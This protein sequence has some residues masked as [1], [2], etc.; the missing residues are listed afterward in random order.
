VGLTEHAIVYAGTSMESPRLLDIQ[1]G[2]VA[3]F[4]RQG[5]HKETVNEDAVAVIPAPGDA[6][7][8]VVADGLGGLPAGDMASAIAVESLVNSIQGAGEYSLRESILDGIEHANRKILD[9]GTGAATTLAVV[10][11]RN[12]ILRSYHIGD[13]GVIVTGQRGRRRLQTVS[14]SPTGYAQEA[15][16]INEAEALDHEERNLVSNVVG[17]HDLRIEIG[18]LLRIA[19]RDTVIVASDG[20]LDNFLSEEIIEY[21]RRGKMQLAATALAVECL[22]RME[23][24]DSNDVGGHPDDI[25]FILYRRT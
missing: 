13:A 9:H 21:I 17:S 19:P 4:T 22:S 1:A 24:G 8:L 16:L 11:I 7:V 20:L 18:S 12:N 3:V 23:R 6:V 5:P 14:H 25:S 10:E 15:G 2:K